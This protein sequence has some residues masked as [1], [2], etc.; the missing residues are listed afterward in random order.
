MAVA[1]QAGVIHRDLKPANVLVNNE[2]LLKIVDFGVAAAASSGSIASAS[3]CT[4]W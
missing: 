3:S 1:H 4:R 2:G